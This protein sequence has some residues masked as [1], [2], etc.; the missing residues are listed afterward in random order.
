MSAFD[1]IIQKKQREWKAPHMMEGIHANRGKKIKF[2][3]PLLNYATYGGIPRDKITEFFGEPGG[4][5]STTAI[6][7]CKNASDVFHEEYEDRLVELRELSTREAKLELSELEDSG[8]RKILYIDLEHSFDTAWSTTLGIDQTDIELMQPP[9]VPAE[10]ILQTVI[11]LIESNEVGLI[12]LDSIP[13]LVTQAELDKKLG[14]RTVSSLAGLMTVFC[15]K[16]VSLLSRYH[17]T[18]ILINQIRDNMDNPYV[19][20]TPGGQAVRFYSSLRMC[21]MLGNPIDIMGNELPKK[22]ED[23]AG[24]LIRV[25]IVKQKSAP[26]DRKV[27]SYYLL[28]K[29]GINPSMDYTQLALKKYGIISKAGAWFTLSDPETGEVL[30]ENDKPVKLNGLL[31]VYDYL[32]THPEYFDCLK[33]VIES[34]INGEDAEKLEE[35]EN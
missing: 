2:S 13:S 3:S 32:N 28:S 35:S 4:G 17:T 15:R 26:F 29:S 27:A 10:Q 19:I 7:I 24:Y 23:P 14:E 6:D 31:K 18:L 16:V 11:D 30:E 8:P 5:K 1:D 33:K 34:D 20:H 9:D 25:Q 21:F 22:S 12:I